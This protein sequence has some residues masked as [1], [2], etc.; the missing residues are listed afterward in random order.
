M[1]PFVNVFIYFEKGN[2]GVFYF[3]LKQEFESQLI[4]AKSASI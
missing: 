4:D 1:V 2:G 3:N